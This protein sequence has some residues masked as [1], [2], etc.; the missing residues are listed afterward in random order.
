M[1]TAVLKIIIACVFLE[2]VLIHAINLGGIMRCFTSACLNFSSSSFVGSFSYQSR[3]VTSSK[4]EKRANSSIEY[5]L[6]LRIP[7]LPLI[8]QREDAAAYTP[9]RP[10]FNSPI[11]LG[12]F[13]SLLNLRKHPF[14]NFYRFFLFLYFFL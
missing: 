6:Y 10:F 13:F 7:F 2:R 11:I 5:P 8:K 9:S 12:V 3:N 1:E 4:Q 14:F